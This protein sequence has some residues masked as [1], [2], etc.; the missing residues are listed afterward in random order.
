MTRVSNQQALN[1]DERLD[2]FGDTSA[3]CAALAAREPTMARAL[4]TIDAPHIRRRDSGF[5]GLFR[6]IIEQ[7]VSVPSAQAILGRC[8]TALDPLTPELVRDAGAEKLKG[9]GLS[10]P[11]V[12]YILGLCDIVLSGALSFEAIAAM[13][14]AD[15]LE[16]LQ[17]I[18]GIGP[19]T[20][21]I[22]LLFCEGRA[23]IWPPNDV[24]LKH[25][26]NAAKPRKP[27]Y[28]QKTLDMRAARWAP[29][30]GVAAHI[31]WTFY[32]DLRGRT[33]I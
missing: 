3:A 14:D 16:K 26:Y 2:V 33:P 8:V 15:A 18:K 13:D 31:L 28:D 1:D 19:W 7:Q 22:Y 32:A 29:Y 11:K 5:A 24:A 12:R 6:I 25:A 20:A 27:D 9:L 10:G 4:A 23:D 17:T 21:S 30:R